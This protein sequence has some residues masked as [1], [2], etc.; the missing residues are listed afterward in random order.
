MA[1]VRECDVCGDRNAFYLI[2]VSAPR[3]EGRPRFCRE[4]VLCLGCH[5]RLLEEPFSAITMAVI[6]R[7]KERAL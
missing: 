3:L 4:F 6:E 2:T 5:K 1:I 7:E